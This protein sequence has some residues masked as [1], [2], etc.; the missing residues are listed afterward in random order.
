MVRRCFQIEFC[1]I[2]G[3]SWSFEWPDLSNAIVEAELSLTLFLLPLI[4]QW[5]LLHCLRHWQATKLPNSCSGKHV[6]TW[7]VYTEPRISIWKVCNS[8][9][10]LWNA[11]PPTLYAVKVRH[12]TPWSRGP[13]SW[14]PQM[15]VHAL[16]I[17]LS[18]AQSSHN[19]EIYN[20]GVHA[21]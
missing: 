11:F 15:L 10:Y 14:I 21:Q 8:K 1:L 19:S 2:L 7:V 3:A 20:I 16:S 18:M 12:Y 5:I 17:S 13:L 6:C 4:A 9:C